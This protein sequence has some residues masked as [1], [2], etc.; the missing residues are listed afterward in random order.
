MMKITNSSVKYVISL[1]FIFVYYSLIGLISKK[2][3]QY[4]LLS[5][6]FINLYVIELVM[7]L[8]YAYFWQKIIKKFSITTAY[9][10][11]GIVILWTLLWSFLIFNET[12]QF[13][14]IIGAVII[15]IGIIVVSLDGR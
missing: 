6:E 13:K 12:V 9:A 4:N 7:I 11:K 10:S 5:K 2:A 15:I 14:N 3:A 1:Q 8:I